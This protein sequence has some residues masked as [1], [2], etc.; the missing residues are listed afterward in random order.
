[1][2]LHAI[3]TRNNPSARQNMDWYIP[4]EGCRNRGSRIGLV[5]SIITYVMRQS[6]SPSNSMDTATDDRNFEQFVCD[7]YKYLV[8][9]YR[10]G[11]RLYIMGFSRGAYTA[12]ALAGMIQRVSA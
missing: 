1:M 7:A 4:A 3:E 9:A 5:S 2:I 10:T 8:D 6:L 12:R 11:D